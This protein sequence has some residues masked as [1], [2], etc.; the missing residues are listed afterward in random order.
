MFPKT[1]RERHLDRY[2]A[3]LELERTNEVLSFVALIITS[4]G[5]YDADCSLELN[6]N[7]QE[8]VPPLLKGCSHLCWRCTHWA[9]AGGLSLYLLKFIPAWAY[10]PSCLREIIVVYT[11]HVLISLSLSLGIKG[12]PRISRAHGVCWCTRACSKYNSVH[13][14]PL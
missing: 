9:Y 7:L 10:M 6:G 2:K 8:S 13:A 1:D 11:V 12:C 5:L 14:V 4:F 3:E